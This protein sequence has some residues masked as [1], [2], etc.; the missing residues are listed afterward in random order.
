[1]KDFEKFDLNEHSETIATTSTIP[2]EAILVTHESLLAA[3][4]K[5][6]G[7]A[8]YGNGNKRVTNFEGEWCSWRDGK[9]IKVKY[10]FEI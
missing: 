6:I 1:M 7:N 3:G 2:K 9:C 10:T 8:Y 4:F 5:F